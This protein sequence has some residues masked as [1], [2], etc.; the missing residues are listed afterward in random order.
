MILKV[1]NQL[2]KHTAL[3][4]TFGVQ[5]LALVDQQPRLLS[6][7]R[8]LQI[9]IDHRVEVLTRR[10]HFELEKAS[11]RQHILEGY[12][13]AL[14]DVDAVIQTIRNSADVDEAR[15]ALMENFGLSQAQAVAILDLQLRRL[16]GLERRKIQ[17]EF[18][19]KKK[20]IVSWPAPRG[21]EFRSAYG[22]PTFPGFALMLTHSDTLN[23][24][25]SFREK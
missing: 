8:A 7:K 4:T 9:H 13:I 24:V 22:L 25:Y 23:V 16:A 15:T 1:L 12:L 17:D 6:L 11:K 5:M 21:R 20:E 2:Y 3:Q 19:E 18:K 10:T 14:Q